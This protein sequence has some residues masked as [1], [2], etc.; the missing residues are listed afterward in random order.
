MKAPKPNNI[1]LI[2]TPENTQKKTPNFPDTLPSDGDKILNTDAN[3][4]ALTEFVGVGFRLNMMTFEPE[5]FDKGNGDRLNLSGEQIR[6]SLQS[7]AVRHSLTKQAVDDHMQAL[8]E[9]VKYHPVKEWLDS[10]NWDGVNRIDKVIDCINASNLVLAQLVLKRWLVGVVASLYEPS[11]KSKLV[12]IL[13]GEQSFRKTAF[14]ERL[15]LILPQSFLEGAELNPDNKDSVLS[16]IKS[17]IVE[18]GELERTNKNSQGSLKAFITKSLDTVRPP[19][20]RTDIKKPRQTHFIATVN[21]KD[22]LKDETGS[23]RFCVIEM[24]EPANMDMVNQILGWQY[25]GTGSLKQVKPELLR[26][27]WLEVNELYQSGYGWMM[28]DNEIKLTAQVNEP[29]NDKGCWYDYILGAYLSSDEKTVLDQ[30][31]CAADLVAEDPKLNAVSTKLIGKA[32]AKLYREK[33]LECK[34]RGGG[35]KLYRKRCPLPFTL[36]L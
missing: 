2:L 11:F 9:K 19:Y 36:P 14:I 18:L 6:S 34:T 16:C 23:S 32:L 22:F 5:V 10:G 15:A 33:Y 29:Y 20:A 12:P 3:L 27:F 7:E 24:E 28:S 17:L 30:W 35:T 8:S 4:L 1:S 13:Q 31:K 25:D 21:G 26:Q